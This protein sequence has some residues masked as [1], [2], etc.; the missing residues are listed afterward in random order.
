MAWL[1]A[2]TFFPSTKTGTVLLAEKAISAF[3]VN[4]QG[5]VSAANPLC[6][7]AILVRQQ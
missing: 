7:S 6:A 2:T 4:R 3:S 1:S 5:M